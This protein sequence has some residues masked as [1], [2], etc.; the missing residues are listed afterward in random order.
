MVVVQ[1]IRKD[2][3]GAQAAAFAN[4]WDG[5]TAAL[6]RRVEERWSEEEAEDGERQEEV[7]LEV[8]EQEERMVVE[9]GDGRKQQHCLLQRVVYR[10]LVCLGR[11]EREA[12]CHV[13]P[14]VAAVAVGT[15]VQDYSTGCVYAWAYEHG[16]VL[17]AEEK[18]RG[19]V[20]ALH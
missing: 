15:V 14:H 7:G 8:I 3:T 10:L 16:C 12:G 6:T 5:M 19:T 17:H 11:R 18:A 9:R 4:A 20:L 2:P 13:A 1:R